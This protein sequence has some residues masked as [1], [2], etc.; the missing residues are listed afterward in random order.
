MGRCHEAVDED[1]MGE[2]NPGR[3]AESSV[4]LW[5]GMPKLHRCDGLKVPEL[6]KQ[7]GDC[8]FP[9]LLRKKYTII[10]Q[11]CAKHR[12]IRKNWTIR[13]REH[14]WRNPFCEFDAFLKLWRDHLYTGKNN[15][16]FQRQIAANRCRLSIEPIRSWPM[17]TQAPFF[18]RIHWFTNYIEHVH[19]HPYRPINGTNHSFK[20]PILWSL[21]DTLPWTVS[22]PA[23]ICC[24]L[25]RFH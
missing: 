8:S 4:A 17:I 23:L 21:S 16:C 18:Q 5:L 2:K 1:T 25:G 7:P 24:R 14:S 6:M 22:P 10:C 15:I 11:A 12:P 3:P 19:R 20:Q 9:H 13:C